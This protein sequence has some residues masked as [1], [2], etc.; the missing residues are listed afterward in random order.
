MDMHDHFMKFI[1]N[2]PDPGIIRHIA[3]VPDQKRCFIFMIP[4]KGQVKKGLAPIYRWIPSVI[5]N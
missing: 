3:I 5:Q 4:Q 2:N 1:D